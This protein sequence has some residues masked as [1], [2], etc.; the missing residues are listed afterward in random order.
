MSVLKERAAHLVVKQS[1]NCSE[2]ARA[3]TGQMTWAFHQPAFLN[4]NPPCALWVRMLLGRN[5]LSP[6]ALDWPTSCVLLWH[7][8][9]YRYTV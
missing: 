6:T 9:G 8:H 7:L 3:D 1:P 4:S 2:V 5:P